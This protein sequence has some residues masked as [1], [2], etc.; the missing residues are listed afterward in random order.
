MSFACN[1]LTLFDD[2]KPRIAGVSTSENFAKWLRSGTTLILP[3]LSQAK[4]AR[5]KSCPPKHRSLLSSYRLNL[6][7]GQQVVHDMIVA[8]INASIDLGASKH[9]TDL[10][11]V[12]HAFNSEFPASVRPTDCE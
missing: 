4:L 6:T 8:D 3:G 1:H 11:V 9:A 12:L 10:S 2:A 7:R 5:A